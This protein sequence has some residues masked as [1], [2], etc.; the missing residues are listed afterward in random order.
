MT[1]GRGPPTGQN[2]PCDPAGCQALSELA[3]GYAAFVRI[4]SVGP[5]RVLL[6]F[7]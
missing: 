3:S 7:I 1:A 2:G 4:H 5:L 6:R